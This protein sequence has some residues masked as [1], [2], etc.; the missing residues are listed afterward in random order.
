MGMEESTSAM[1][2]D[3]G[4]GQHGTARRGLGPGICQTGGAV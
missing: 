3:V 2:V 1:G 4:S